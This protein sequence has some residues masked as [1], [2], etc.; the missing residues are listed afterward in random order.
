MPRLNPTLTSLKTYPMT[1][2]QQ[3]K[4]ALVAAGH[5]LLDFSIGDPVEPTPAFIRQAM[6]DAITPRCG[7]PTVRGSTAV[8]SAIA[9]Y[10]RRRFGVTLDPDRQVLPTAGSRE[11]VFHL[12]LL[13]IDPQADDRLVVFP[14]P[15]YPAYQRGALF[16]G[17]TPHPV[18]LS[19]DFVFRPWQ[20]PAEILRRTRLLWVNSP[21]NPSGAV[22]SLDDLQRIADV[23]REYDILCVSDESYAD[24]Y[25]QHPPHSMLECGTDNIIVLHTLSKRSSMTGYRSGFLAGDPAMMASLETL[26]SNPG[27]VPQDFVNAAAAAAWMDDAHVAERR[28]ICRAKKNLFLAFFDEANIEVIGKEATLYLWI[29]VPQGLGS[30]EQWAERLL[31]AGLVVSPGSMFGVYGGGAGYVRLALVPSLDECQEAI[32][33]W[34]TLL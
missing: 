2:L 34:R 10:V 8:R 18:E 11:A 12:P 23:C 17:G 5:R 7:Y 13:V 1:A 25:H 19:G 33:I 16:A 24:I 4:A 3:R 6:Q 31:E 27:L 30:A 29:K 21:H 9:D 32:Q 28:A 26:R 20:L 14:D 15:G 22:N